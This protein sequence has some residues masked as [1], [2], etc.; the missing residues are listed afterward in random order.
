MFPCDV[1]LKHGIMKL[2]WNVVT[3]VPFDGISCRQ[4]D[5]SVRKT[6]FRESRHDTKFIITDDHFSH[7]CWEVFID[8]GTWRN[9]V[10]QGLRKW[11]SIGM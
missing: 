10:K 1:D 7:N 8:Y 9:L 6:T 5:G 3:L 4:Y 11:F 2:C